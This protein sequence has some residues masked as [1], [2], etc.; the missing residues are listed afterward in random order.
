MVAKKNEVL[1]A[2][3]ILEAE[4]YRKKAADLIASA[5]L[6]PDN[7]KEAFFARAKNE[8]MKAIEIIQKTRKAIYNPVIE[9]KLLQKVESYG[10]ITNNIEEYLKRL[11]LLSKLPSV[12]KT[13]P[14]DEENQENKTAPRPGGRKYD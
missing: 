7:Q 9:K 6:Y 4:K 13:N 8:M 11:S 3:A 2:Y 1:Y 12:P 10:K 14:Q 5:R